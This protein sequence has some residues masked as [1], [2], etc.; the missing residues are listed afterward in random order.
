MAVGTIGLGTRRRGGGLG[1]LL[2][3]ERPVNAPSLVADYDGWRMA[4]PAEAADW[5]SGSL[6]AARRHWRG[7]AFA[8]I[9]HRPCASRLPAMSL[10]TPA[11]N[12][13]AGGRLTG[14]RSRHGFAAWGAALSKMA[15]GDAPLPPAAGVGRWPA[16]RQPQWVAK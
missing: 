5:L 6:V 11:S 3:S 4:G 14:R 7:V 8:A 1:A 16:G 13:R 12:R 10:A 2:S 9:A 15:K